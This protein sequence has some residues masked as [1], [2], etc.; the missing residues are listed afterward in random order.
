M[1][2]FKYLSSERID[3]LKNAHIGFTPPGAFN[4]PFE[5]FPY[6]KAIA[7]KWDMDRF[8]EQ[9]GWDQRKIEDM[10][11]ESWEAQLQKYPNLKIPFSSVKGLMTAMLEQARPNLTDHFKQFMT[12][13]GETYR[14]L[15]IDTLLNAMNREIGILCLTEKRDNLLMWAHYAS[16]HSGFVVQFDTESSYFDQRKKTDEIRGHLRKVRYAKKQPELVLMDRNLSQEQTIDRWV[17]DIFF[18]K[19]KHWEYEQEWRMAMTL[20]DCQRVIQRGSHKIHL[21]PFPKDSV[22][23]LILGC[24][25]SKE[26]KDFIIKIVEQDAD[27]SHVE[28]IQA[29][30]D[31]KKYRLKFLAV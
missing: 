22:R 6:F 3:V 27:Y 31:D 18:V 29:K 23:A 13:D 15:A 25:I 19:S 17:D 30:I 21:F 20:R 9:K 28:I 2:I 5:S 24:K 26:D 7:P 10:L 1:K 12:V 16:N 11:E 8:I 4:D 14:E